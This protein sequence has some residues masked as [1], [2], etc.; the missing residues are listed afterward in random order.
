LFSV[1]NN[2]FAQDKFEKESRIKRRDV[3][4]KAL[5]FMDSLSYNAKIKW[6][7]EEAWNSESIEAKFK[8][9]KTKYSIEY[10]TH[11]NI[12]DVEIEVHWQDLDNELSK[13]ITNQLKQDCSKHKIVKIQ[14]QFTGTKNDLFF[15]LRNGIHSEQIKIKYEMVVRCNEQKEVNLLEYLFNEK[16]LLVIK[17]KIIFKNS[18]H[19]EY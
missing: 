7:K 15:L 6:Y 8:H 2:L 4:S 17:S 11:G 1:S 16:G 10:D 5:F 3:P 9:N 18:S 14:R 12:E 19:L 13:S